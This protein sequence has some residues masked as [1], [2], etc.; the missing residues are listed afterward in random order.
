MDKYRPEMRKYYYDP[1]STRPTSSSSASSIR[2]F[3]IRPRS[4]RRNRRR[5]A[6]RGGRLFGCGINF[7]ICCGGVLIGAPISLAPRR[8]HR[9]RRDSSVGP[10]ITHRFYSSL[11]YGSEAEFNPLY[12]IVEGRIRSDCGLARTGRSSSSDIGAACTQ[13]SHHHASRAGDSALRLEELARAR[14]VSAVAQGLGRR[15]VVSELPTPPVRRRQDL[16]AN[17]GMVRAAWRGASRSRLGVDDVR[18][19][20]PR[21]DGREQRRLLRGRRRPQRSHDLRSGAIILWNQPWMRR[22]FSGRV[23]FTDWPGQ[24]AISLPNKSIENAYN[25]AMFRVPFPRTDDWKAMTTMGNAFLFGVSRRVGREQW[26]SATGGFDPS[27]NPVV[28]RA[29]ARRALRAAEC[30][31]VPRSKGIV[32]RVVHHQG[33]QQQRT[34]A[35]HLSG[36][37]RL[38]RVVAGRVGPRYSRRRFSL[39]HRLAVRDRA[40]RH[41][42]DKQP[43]ADRCPSLAAAEYT[44]R[45]D[46]SGRSSHLG[47]LNREL[48]LSGCR[49][50]R[51]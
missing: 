24:A 13:C 49:W 43:V 42:D 34:H 7:S 35:Q 4:Y 19:A 41:G 2:R 45:P 48:A 36:S 50:S 38:R 30:R 10:E 51:R 28:D 6:A 5:R 46:L 14:G 17:G 44:N 23:E 31:S 47:L 21:R 22:A 1:R 27:D 26:L 9:R 12:L 20:L 16:L 33:R 25:M 8:S 15:A 39:R 40:R 29:P 37:D 32:A 11:P 3:V 18:V